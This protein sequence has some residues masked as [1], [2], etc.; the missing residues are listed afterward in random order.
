V[1]HSI[2]SKYCGSQEKGLTG[3]G[4]PKCIH[5]IPPGRGETGRRRPRTGKIVQPAGS[6]RHPGHGAPLQQ[7]QGQ[8]S[9]G[10]PA[11]LAGEWRLC[12]RAESPRPAA[13]DSRP[14]FRFRGGGETSLHGILRAPPQ[15][16][17]V[18]PARQPDVN[19]RGPTHRP[20]PAGAATSVILRPS[21]HR[22]RRFLI[23][24]RSYDCISS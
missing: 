14:G 13:N 16:S 4:D 23:P 21:R 12:G 1:N 20:P 10:V 5:Q 7:R 17:G 18:Q 9:A 2:T 15:A 3:R 11:A 22:I 19:H 6:C 8:Q 24:A